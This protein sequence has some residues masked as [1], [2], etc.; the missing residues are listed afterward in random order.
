[1]DRLKYELARLADSKDYKTLNTFFRRNP[2]A[3]KF[4]TRTHNE[5]ISQETKLFKKRNGKLYN[6]ART[7]PRKRAK[8]GQNDIYT[9]KSIYYDP[10]TKSLGVIQILNRFADV[11]RK[12]Q[13]CQTIDSMPVVKGAEC[14]SKVQS[15]DPGIG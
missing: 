2:N 12:T 8:P 1:M 13:V 4:D 9:F 6:V 11:I 3:S 7:V 15:Q 10:N 5:D 14:I